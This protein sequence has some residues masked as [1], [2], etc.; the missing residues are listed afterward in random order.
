MKS[1]LVA[2]AGA[3]FLVGLI[4]LLGLLAGAVMAAEAL[5]SL[6]SSDLAQG[7]F[8]YMHMLLQ[9]TILK[10]NIA[11]IEVRVDKPTQNRLTGLLSGQSY[12]EGLAQQLAHGVVSAE[13]AVVQMQFKRDISL[14]RWMGFTRDNIEQARKAGLITADLEKRVSQALPQSFAAIKSRGYE[15]GDRLIYAIT[16]G[17]LRTAVVSAGGQVFID[18]M[19]TEQGAQ[20]VVLAAFFAPGSDFREP[21]LRSLLETTR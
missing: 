8:S 14:D 17:G 10:I 2:A 5:P 9:K 6:N 7:P 12:S 15:K 18:R 4:G 20:R 11:T 1:S 19:D 16:P 13:R 21:L 3:C